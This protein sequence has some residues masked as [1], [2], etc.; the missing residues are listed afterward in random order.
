MYLASIMLVK[1]LID[2]FLS[3]KAKNKPIQISLTFLVKKSGPA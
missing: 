1:F 3:Q 2:I